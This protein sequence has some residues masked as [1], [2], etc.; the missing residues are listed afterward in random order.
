SEH[1]GAEVI[2][3]IR[4]AQAA[5]CNGAETQVY[6][7]D[8]G[9]PDEDFAE[10]TRGGKRVGFAAR[11]LHGDVAGRFAGRVDEIEVRALRCVDQSQQATQRPVRIQR[12]HALKLLLDLCDNGSGIL[13]TLLKVAFA[14]RIELDGEQL[15]KVV[16]DLRVV[17]QRADL[18]G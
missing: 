10:R 9:R 7:F 3:P 8:I 1:F 17:R 5:A 14:G 11:D 4:P 13:P 15:N 2:P 12:G 18:H 16:R 6:A